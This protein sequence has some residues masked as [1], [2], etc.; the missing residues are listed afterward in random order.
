MSFR[1]TGLDPEQFKPL[2]ALS[3]EQLAA[4][5][6]K[7][8]VADSKPGFPCRVT[9]RDAD[10]GESLLLLNYE[11]LPV[12][13]P[14]RSNHAIFVNE[15]SGDRYD[16]I[17]RVPEVMLARLLSV[18]SFDAEGMMLDADVLEGP[19]LE[20]AIPRFFEDHRAEYLHV[21]YAKRG[22]FSAR[23]DRVK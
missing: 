1:I 13:S 2:F 14:Y 11:H 23:V 20:A 19:Q 3:D 6:I 7:R 15:N 21:H 16:E 10:P 9:L 18:R 8:V 17:D 5:T 4:R 12:D 22:C